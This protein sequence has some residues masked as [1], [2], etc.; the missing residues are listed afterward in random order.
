M[1]ALFST[2]SVPQQD[3]FDYWQDVVSLS[4]VRSRMEF[5]HGGDFYGEIVSRPVGAL[6][7]S[8]IGAAPMTY[9]RTDSH[10]RTSTP[11]VV[12]LQIQLEGTSLVAQDGRET[13]T[14]SGDMCLLDP[15]RPVTVR[16]HEARHVVLTMPRPGLQRLVGN[17]LPLTARSMS[18][19]SGEGVLAAGF[20]RTLMDTPP[21]DDA[22]AL[23]NI[24]AQA[25]DVAALAVTQGAAATVQRL[26]SPV[27]VSR[28]RLHH[29]IEACIFLPAIR[30]DDV[31]GMAGISARYANVLLA[32]EGTS[33][34]RLIIKRRL[35]K[36]R[37]ALTDPTQ[38]HRSIGDIARGFGFVTDAHFARCF[39]QAYG[40]TAR[41]HRRE[42]LAAILSL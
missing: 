5:D 6:N 42:G 25:M 22:S 33:L 38:M 3:R 34:E 15:W 24:V 1:S 28:L 37:A 27:S 39:K 23:A 17:V 2:A 16:T 11:D 30:C 31:A 14:R 41:E 21:P 19:T 36:C 18:T 13:L 10:A 8:T 40:L 4:Y 26:S 20:I 12:F 32:Q 35:E 7:V 9:D 29:A